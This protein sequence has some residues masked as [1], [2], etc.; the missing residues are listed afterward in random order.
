MEYLR[1]HDDALRRSLV[2]E[3][4][5]SVC[6]AVNVLLPTSNPRGDL[7]FVILEATKYPM[8]SGSNTMCVATVI[9]ETG[10]RPI[11]EP[12]TTLMLEAP[13]GLV[14]ARCH[15]RDGKVERVELT[16]LPSFVL[17]QSIAVVVPGLGNVDLAV[18]L[19]GIF[20]AIASAQA[21]GISLEPG[22]AARIAAFAT[23]SAVRAG[24]EVT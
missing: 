14:E 11:Q 3:P 19:G 9:L 1:D 8:M 2:F 23:A 22:S 7:G 21:L 10:I 20:Y 4:R 18:A 17:E 15:C 24:V 5:G 12:V 13:G 16:M 6:Q